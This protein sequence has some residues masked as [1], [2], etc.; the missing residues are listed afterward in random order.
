MR[1][2]NLAS[3]RELLPGVWKLS[4]LGC[5]S[6]EHKLVTAVSLAGDEKRNEHP[7]KPR[8]R[9]LTS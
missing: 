7:G 1:R 6:T 3:L 8:G 5:F 2:V 9:H 4:V